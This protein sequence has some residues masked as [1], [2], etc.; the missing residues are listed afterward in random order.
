[1]TTATGIAT[2]QTLAKTNVDLLQRSV[3]QTEQCSTFFPKSVQAL[4]SPPCLLHERVICFAPL[5]VD[6]RKK[7]K[8]VFFDSNYALTV[9]DTF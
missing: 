7:F 8:M 9:N 2:L 4:V 1:M 3:S 5:T 6:E